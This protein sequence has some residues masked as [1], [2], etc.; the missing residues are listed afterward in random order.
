MNSV[1]KRNLFLLVISVLILVLVVIS[2]AVA[3]RGPRTSPVEV[4]SK[5]KDGTLLIDD[6]NDGKMTIP[7]FDIPTSSYDIDKFTE[8]DGIITYENGQSAL[9][10]N[11][12]QNRG[13]IDWVKV[14]ESG[15][16]FAMIRAG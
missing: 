2:V 10:I 15:V 11:V 4:V 3:M 1:K 14:K 6:L 12:N 9:G 16:E 5:G 8:K 13:D 7:D